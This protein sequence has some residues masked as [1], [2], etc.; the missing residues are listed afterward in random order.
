MAALVL[1]IR[2]CGDGANKSNS[3]CAGQTGGANA[4]AAPTSPPTKFIVAYIGAEP[5]ALP[6]LIAQ[7]AGIFRKHGLEV[8]LQ[9]IAGAPSIAALV[10]G[11]IQSTTGG[12]SDILGAAVGGA[13][14]VVLA[15]LDASFPGQMYASPKIK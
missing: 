1:A 13:E 14:P 11:Q 8:D 6:I 12:S 7:D 4:S 10:S 3:A 9:V 2:E 15:V 5:A